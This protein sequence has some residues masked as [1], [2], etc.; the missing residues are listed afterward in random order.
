MR[1]ATTGTRGRIWHWRG[2]PIAMLVAM[3]VITAPAVSAADNS[4]PPIRELSYEPW[5]D[6]SVI[7]A[8]IGVTTAINL[9]EP[10]HEACRWCERGSL[11]TIDRWFRDHLKSG[12]PAGLSPLVSAATGLTVL[13][14]MG[15]NAFDAWRGGASARTAGIDALIVV[16]AVAVTLAA[17]SAAKVG[18][19]RQRPYALDIPQAQFDAEPRQVDENSSFFSGHTALAFAVVTSAGTVASLRGY[20]LAPLIW[21]V[22]VPLA[23]S[24]LVLRISQDEHYFTDVAT[25]AAVGTAIGLAVPYLLH[26]R[27]PIALSA[28]RDHDGA[29]VTLSGRF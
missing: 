15:L 16:E 17:T 23:T 10:E 21:A 13:G 8:G 19:Y 7:L 2:T 25:G 12:N 5:V 14:T 22:G 20:R 27:L 1:R 26:R 24:V 3:V 29:R 6:V 28:A 9:G 18:F 4:E 11:N